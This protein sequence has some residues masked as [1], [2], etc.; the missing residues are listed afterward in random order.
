MG[1]EEEEGRVHALSGGRGGREE[2]SREREKEVMSEEG[3]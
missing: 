2:K 3:R 1:L